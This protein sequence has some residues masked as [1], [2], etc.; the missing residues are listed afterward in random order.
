[1]SMEP[2][3]DTDLRPV[4]LRLWAERKH[5]AA[6]VMVAGVLGVMLA[7]VLPKWY[8][9]SALL[10]PPEEADLLSNLSIM[11]SALSKFPA[12][13]EF[14]EYSTPADLYKAILRSRTVQGEVVDRFEL[15]KVY[16][17]KSRELTL[18]RFSKLSSVKMNPDGTI[19]VTVDDR[20][21]KRAALMAQALIDGLDRFNIEKRNSQ[22][23]R[24]REF[25]ER[26]VAETDS[27]LRAGEQALRLYQEQNKAVAPV[28]G[29]SGA[30]MKAAADIM[31]Q[32]L[33]LEVRVGVLSSYMRENSDQLLQARRELAELDRQIGRLPA[34]Q[35]KLGR[36]V[37]DT[38]VQEQLFLLLIAQ[39]EEARVK[40]T[41]DTP[42][43]TVLDPP[44]V[45]ERPVRPRKAVFGGVAA[46]LGLIAASAQV[47]S[48]SRS[49]PAA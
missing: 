30:D 13:G 27:T 5:L 6:T 46:L 47:L 44:L 10:L 24:A 35:S 23:R 43:V 32:K 48:R 22:G 11:G 20:D 33:A 19:A 28:A 49:T 38:K 12:L 9:A 31:A 45:P 14:G 29:P 4:F 41:R 16:R 15:S 42:T 36:L 3:S 21:P 40:E 25:L 37:R 1:M 8:R 2:S 34:L 18:K 7:F 26:R 17:L 39:L